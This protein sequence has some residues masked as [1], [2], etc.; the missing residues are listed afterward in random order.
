MEIELLHRP[1]ASW[2]DTFS[3]NLAL[4]SEVVERLPAVIAA[5]GDKAAFHFVEFFT[6]NIRNRNTRRAYARAA[7]AF[8]R[9]CDQ[10]EV[11]LHQVTPIVVS[12][13]IEVQ[14]GAPQS[15]NQQLA[16]IR[17]LFDHLVIKQVIPGN[18]AASVHGVAHVA[19]TGKTPVLS[20]EDTRRLLDSIDVSTPVGLRDRALIGVMVF[21]FARVGAVVKMNVGDFYKNGQ[22]HHI[23]LTEKGGRFHEVPAH[24][25]AEQFLRTYVAAAG[26]ASERKKPLFRTALMFSDLLSENRMSENDVLRMIKRRAANAGLAESTCCHTFRATGI[27]LYLENGGILENAQRL[28]AHESPRTTK[29]YDRTVVTITSDEMER[30]VI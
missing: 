30:I 8:M 24:S 3:A 18:P 20:G 16:A 4:P 17:M 10:H 22:S 28:A 5:A 12:A 6:A 19:K 29:L 26:I 9:F 14:K 7:Y 1:E 21:S 23:R 25:Q 15:V 27:T 13:Y 2:Q 11:S